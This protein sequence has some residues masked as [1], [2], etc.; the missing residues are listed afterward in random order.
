VIN[1]FIES[2]PDGSDRRGWESA[3]FLVRV[4]LGSPMPEERRC[5]KNPDTKSVEILSESGAAAPPR[6]RKALRTS[7]LLHRQIFP[8]AEE[9]PIVPFVPHFERSAPAANQA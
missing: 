1:V 6:E 4:L 8:I 3:L 7:T 9:I 5:L 2:S